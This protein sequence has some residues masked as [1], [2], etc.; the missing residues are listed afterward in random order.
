MLESVLIVCHRA[1]TARTLSGRLTPFAPEKTVL[2]FTEEQARAF[3]RREE[4]VLI[5]LFV[6]RPG[7]VE[8]SLARELLG[9]TS[10]AV[11]LLCEQGEEEI[12]AEL[13]PLG[14]LVLPVSSDEAMFRR[15]IALCQATYVRM[16]TMRREN[17]RLQKKIE[18]SKIINRAKCILMEYLSMSESQA[19]KYL[20]RQAMD[21]RL[22]KVEVAKNLLSTYD[23]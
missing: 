4:F 2:A 21:L 7:G 15:G 13:S 18:D 23:S 3:C 20:E 17:I 9:S 11:A 5:L 16:C 19:H 8:V 10:S 22:P 1:E 6:P 14:G 12:E